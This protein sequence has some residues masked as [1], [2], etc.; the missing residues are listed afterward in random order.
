MTVTGPDRTE[1]SSEATRLSDLFCALAAIPSPSN[2]ERACGQAVT[3]ELESLGLN[4]RSD[5]AG[6][7]VGSDCDNLYCQIPPTTTG[8]PLFLCAHLDTVP[9][10]ADLEPVLIDG[11]LRNATPSIVGADNKAAVAVIL[12]TIRT[13][14]LDE[15]PHAG[16]ELVF[17]IGEERGLVGSTA[18]D[19]SIIQARSGYVLDHPG[20]IGGYVEAAP[21]RFVVRAQMHGRASHSAIAPEE[22]INAIVPIARAIAAMPVGSAAVNINVARIKGGAAMNVVPDFAELAVDV[23]AVEHAD[24]ERTVAEIEAILQAEAGNAGCTLEIEVR[25]PYSAYRVAPD[26]AALRL[27]RAVFA[28]LDLPVESWVTRGGS[29]A[30]VFCKRGLDCLNLT[31]AVAGFHAPDERVAVADLVLMKTVLLAIIAEAGAER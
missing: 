3:A 16:I 19:S 27:A 29:D 11:V 24:A 14:V 2:F 12:E 9:A 28:E 21:S 31:H 8:R 15:R 23:R 6:A 18:F 10:T 5:S 30:N 7:T 26:S 22:G 1:D 25:H 17:T 13:L 4:V 20:A